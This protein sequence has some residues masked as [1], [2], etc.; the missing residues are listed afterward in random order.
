MGTGFAGAGSEDGIDLLR[1]GQ[2]GT[3]AGGG[4]GAV[5]GGFTSGEGALKLFSRVPTTKD[6]KQYRNEIIT[7]IK[8]HMSQLTEIP[9]YK[10]LLLFS[11][12]LLIFSF[13]IAGWQKPSTVRSH[14]GLK[15]AVK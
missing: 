5:G 9:K 8:D 7:G 10:F 13:Q 6:I 1:G 3:V 11:L 12:Q 4:D 15:C 14:T 2:E